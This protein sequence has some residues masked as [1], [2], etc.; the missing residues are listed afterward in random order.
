MR[1]PSLSLIVTA[2]LSCAAAEGPTDVTRYV[3]AFIGTGGHGHTYP[4][5]TAPFG[6]VQ[7]SPDTYDQGW[8]WCSGYHYSD[9]SI[10]GFS[11]THLS[12]TG[13]GDM[14]DVLVMPGTGPAQTEPGSRERPGSGYRSRFSHSDEAAEPGYYSV[15]LQ[16]YGIKAELTAA[17]RAGVHKYT[18]P[19]SDSAHFIVDLAHGLRGGGRRQANV[20]SSELNVVDSTTL[21]GGRRMRVWAAGRHIYF[22]M[23]FSKPFAAARIISG[24]QTLDESTRQASGTSLKALLD[25]RTTTAGEVI[26][27]KVGISGVSA[28]GAKR[29][30][31]AEVPGRDFDHVRRAAHDL[32]VKELSKI[33][34]ETSNE[35]DRRIFY[36]ALYHTMLA[37]T[38]FDDVDGQYR[39][40]DLEI[41][42]LERGK[43]NYSTYS[44][45]DA[46]RALHP[47][48]TIVQSERVPEFI[49]NLVQ[50]AVE[51]PAGPPVWPLQGR[52][53]GTMTGYHSVVPMAEAVAKG[54]Q[55]I[56]LAP[57]WPA[58]HKRA[59]DD[60]YR[61]MPFYRKLGYIPSDK[62]AESATKTLEYA[63]DDW[64][65]AQ[66]AKSLGKMDDYIALIKRSANWRNLWDKET[67]FIRPRLENGEWAAPFNPQETG[68]SK[69]WRDFTEA[70]SWQA[71]WQAQHDPKGYID[72]LGGKQ[73]MID[74]LDALFTQKPEIKGEIPAD[75]TGLVGMYAHGNEPSHHVAYL[76]PYAGAPYKTQER[77]R[78]LLE[79]QYRDDPD[80][81]SGNED[82]GQMSAWYAISAF[83]FY[84][85]DPAGGN[86][87][88]GSPLF[89]RATVDVGGGRE[90]EIVAKNNGPENKYIQSVVFNGKRYGRSWF[91]HSA[92]AKGGRI[93]FEMGP[94][95]NQQ[96]GAAEDAVPPSM[97]GVR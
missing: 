20:L 46:Y 49:N 80:G 35:K 18:F 34:V 47:L 43:H 63:Y 4:G 1:T 87:V 45:W 41:H 62:E 59:F 94:K 73:G 86:Y 92:I 16:D 89:S 19:A 30:L 58:I 36:T 68:T 17:A 64:A 39:G 53:T 61:G 10:M 24:T 23:K 11:H 67:R 44:L 12:G 82:C 48:F 13:I 42:R 29:N 90:L 26:Y 25:F 57:A 8:D 97:G 7:L 83:G 88:F 66:I 40:M 78:D 76:Y 32:W 70:N 27:V 81:L 6:M 56:D 37:P 14:L 93:V 91:P 28:E 84:A 51:S 77:V 3:N 38:L 95:P 50:M 31:E 33:R 55:G 60:N 74:K 2:A 15:I 5:A 75:M 54:F 79:G 21:T 96:F 9:S 85:V 72:L 65:V 69:K 71:M 22:A 52:E